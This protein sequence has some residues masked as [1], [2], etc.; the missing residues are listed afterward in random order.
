MG[1]NRNFS[2]LIVLCANNIKSLAVQQVND[3]NA[4]FLR[5]I[6]VTLFFKSTFCCDL[7]KAQ[8]T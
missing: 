2:K 6:L 7:T 1:M 3:S 8:P 5:N 4:R